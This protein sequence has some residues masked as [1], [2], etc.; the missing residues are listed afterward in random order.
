MSTHTMYLPPI[1]KIDG[2]GAAEFVVEK[3][4][5]AERLADMIDD[6]IEVSPRPVADR[7]LPQAERYREDAYWMRCALLRFYG[8]AWYLP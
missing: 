6:T 3:L 2:S 7:L 8:R 5:R 4:H 1:T